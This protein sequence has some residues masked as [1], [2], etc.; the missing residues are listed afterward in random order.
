MQIFISHSHK[1][2]EL[3]RKIYEF[4]DPFFD[5]WMWDQD[6]VPGE[7]DWDT[8]ED[9]IENSDLLV[10]LATDDGVG[11]EN[12]WREVDLAREHGTYI[13]PLRGPDTPRPKLGFLSSKTCP[14]MDPD[15]LPRTL[16]FIADTTLRVRETRTNRNYWY[17]GIGGLI[18]GYLIGRK[19]S[20]NRISSS[21]SSKLADGS[22][23]D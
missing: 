10:M 13:L 1:D 2:I 22:A 15:D 5:P 20:E 11:N 19:K 9:A 18:V 12:V 4:L 17:L 14:K 6:M 7:I 21:E 8:I 16:E 3:A 23:E